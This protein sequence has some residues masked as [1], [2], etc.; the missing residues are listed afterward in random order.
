MIFD[1]VMST[2]VWIHSW[3]ITNV[4]NLW[5][6]GPIDIVYAIERFFTSIMASGPA[7]VLLGL[8]APSFLVYAVTAVM[9]AM[10]FATVVRLT[11]WVIG[12]IR[13]GGGGE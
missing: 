4:L 13:G 7:A 11:L 10:V 9:G 2:I 5:P 12:W 8:T 3:F 6:T 1:L